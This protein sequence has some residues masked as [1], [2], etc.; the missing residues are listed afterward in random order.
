MSSTDKSIENLSARKRELFEML[1]RER[2]Q[3]KKSWQITPIPNREELTSF[4]LSFAQ[5]RLWFLDQL[6]PGMSAYNIAFAWRVAGLLDKAAL[7]KSISEI[8]R[9]HEI[10]RATM[11]VVD[12]KPVQ[13]ITPPQAFNVQVM[14]LSD[15]PESGRLARAQGLAREEAGKPFDLS[16]GPLLRVTLLRLSEADH[17]VLCTMHH[18][19]SDGWSLGLLLAEIA[20][21]YNAY[22]SGKPSPLPELPIQYTDFAQCQRDWLQ[23]EVLESQLSYWK[24]QL[25]EIPSVLELPVDRPRPAAPSFR[26]ETV[27]FTV[28]N[29]LHEALKNLSRQEGA[30]LFMTL[31]AAFQALLY[32]Y[33][34]QDDIV[35]GS[36]IANRSRAEIESLIG[37]F[38]NTLVLRTDLSGNPSFRELLG[39]VHQVAVG[40]YEHQD[41][42]FERLVEELRIERDV[43]RNPVFQVMFHLQNTPTATFEL[44]GLTRR[45]F[46]VPE[47]ST[48]MVDLSL[49][50]SEKVDI[51]LGPDLQL[52]GEMEYN[53]D[54]FDRTTV[55]RLVEHFQSLLE[56]IAANPDARILDL[57][58]LKETELQQV[59]LGWNDTKSDYPAQEAWHRLFEAQVEQTPDKVAIADGRRQLTYQELNNRANQIAHRLEALGI[60]A[61]TVVTVF[62]D[63]SIDLI[64]SLI[65]ILKA[66]G[67]YLPLDPAYPRERLSFILE[68]SK[69]PLILTQERFVERLPNSMAH[70]LSLDAEDGI[71]R[72][73]SAI[74]LVSD[75]PSNS[76]AYVIY[77]SGSTGTPKGALITHKSL[78]NHNYAVAR[79]YGLT[80]DDRVLQFASPSFDVSLEE[81]LPSLLSGA[82]VV[83]RDDT[84]LAPNVE[85]LRLLAEQNLTVLNLP[86]SYWHDLV[87]GLEHSGSSIFPS[88]R[89][90][91]IGSEKVSTEKIAVWEKIVESTVAWVNAYGTSETTITSTIYDSADYNKDVAERPSLPIGR[92]IVNVQTYILDS[93]LRPVPIGALG[94]LYIGGDGVARG[95]L[96][97]PELTAERFIANPFSSQSGARM[98]RT[99]D[100]ARYFPDG[101]IE[102]LGRKD[103]QVKIRGYRIELGEIEATLATHQA[104]G[105]CLVLA[106]SST[107]GQARLTAYI[108]AAD[109]GSP[110]ISELRGYLKERLPD[111]M[112]PAAFVLLETMPLLPSG[113]VDREALPEP[114]KRNAEMAA[115]YVAPRNQVERQIS[116]IWQEVLGLEE[117]GVQ[118]NFFDL[119]GHS[120]LMTEIHSRLKQVFEKEVSMVELFEYPTVSA[121][122]KFYGREMIERQAAQQNTESVNKLKEG[123]NRLRQQLR[124]RQ[125]ATKKK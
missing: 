4:P 123:K 56:A 112:V 108:V 6:Q 73:Q 110:S 27:T 19:V 10:L 50:L 63:R 101:N 118:D 93:S 48:S 82:T 86:A 74:N 81:V 71:I 77:T 5:Q 80:P 72:Q 54:I 69:V 45:Q 95:Y 43:R 53:L 7:A 65:A 23:G 22:S 104:V 115:S 103:D 89:L 3:A 47:S 113:K 29:H 14:D 31:L 98:Y 57:P 16:T 114:D 109:G 26:G 88:L 105:E 67:A 33:T 91:V 84:M 13:I 28:P 117:V 90:L 99:G 60:G 51:N 38:V 2:Q 83:L 125:L 96:N 34:G 64:A 15:L 119:G 122:A 8:L 36:P 32:R 62:M 1:L 87:D 55:V 124:Q 46:D 76:L 100:V 75:V 37:F 49:S 116:A 120:L 111:Y 11:T 9:R 35:V 41:L 58:L 68:N 39:R 85:S 18:V 79:Q 107:L 66:G 12:R 121:L 25:A 94:E 20:A 30:T 17:V 97:R 40:A 44:Q 102:L 92:P 21:L 52:I 106:K 70:I 59:L 61:E 42:P 24:K 78:V